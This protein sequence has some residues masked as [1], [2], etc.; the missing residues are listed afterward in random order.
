[1]RISDWSSDVCSSDLKSDP[2]S[3]I[4]RAY[5][6]FL[7]AAAVEAK[8]LAPIEPW[9]NKVRAVDKAGLAALLAEADRN[10]VSHFFGGYVGQDDKNPDV[11]IYSLYQD[12]LGMPDR[13][14]YL[15]PGARNEKLQIAYLT[16]LENMLVLAGETDAAARAQRSE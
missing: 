10:G 9:L 4:G 5:T 15:K 1:M 14:F 11:Y 6:A 13:D 2:N 8:G 12:G 3:K 7:D 16:H